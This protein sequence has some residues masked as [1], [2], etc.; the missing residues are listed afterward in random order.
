MKVKLEVEW[1]DVE[2]LVEDLE[3]ADGKHARVAAIATFLDA[4]T[5]MG[6]ILPPPLGTVLEMWDDALYARLI[7]WGMRVLSRDPEKRAER[8]AKRRARRKKN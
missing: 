2:G 5:P 6:A 1:D 3:D 4:A 8:K 7:K